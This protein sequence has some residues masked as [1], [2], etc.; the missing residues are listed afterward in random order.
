MNQKELKKALTVLGSITVTNDKVCDKVIKLIQDGSATIVSKAWADG[1]KNKN[2]KYYPLDL[3]LDSTWVTY[4]D[5]KF[6]YITVDNNSL[7]CDI[8]CF[9]HKAIEGKVIKFTAEI[10]LPIR[11]INIF[12]DSITYEIKRHCDHLYDDYLEEQRQQ[13]IAKKTA[14]LISSTIRNQKECQKLIK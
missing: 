3:T 9:T 12:N 13:W 11:H 4:Q 5:Y 1:F 6:I 2:P 10:K 8:R 7:C 14:Q